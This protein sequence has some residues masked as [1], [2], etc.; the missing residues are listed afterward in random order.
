MEHRLGCVM[1]AMREAFSTGERRGE[2]EAIAT[3]MEVEA[4]VD[5]I[6]RRVT[7]ET[8]STDA[9]LTRPVRTIMRSIEPISSRAKHGI[10]SSR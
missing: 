7:H 5:A 6:H 10:V 1:E 9:I 3:L 2:A 4:I 8:R